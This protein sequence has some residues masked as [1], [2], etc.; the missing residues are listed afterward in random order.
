MASTS[1]SVYRAPGR[2]HLDRRVERVRRLAPE[3][4]STEEAA[5][6][7][8][9]ELIAE[10]QALLPMVR[11]A[12][13]PTRWNPAPEAGDRVAA[14]RRHLLA[15]AKFARADC[16]S[17]Q[18]SPYRNEAEYALKGYFQLLSP[19]AVGRHMSRMEECHWLLNQLSSAETR[20][21]VDQQLAQLALSQDEPQELVTAEELRVATCVRMSI[22][23]S[24][25]LHELG[26]PLAPAEQSS[27]CG[28]ARR[29]ADLL[30]QLAPT[31]PKAMA[32]AAQLLSAGIHALNQT[33]GRSRRPSQQ[34]VGELAA[35]QVAV[36][37]RYRRGWEGAQQRG[38]DLHLA[39]VG[40]NW[41]IFAANNPQS[42]DQGLI[43]AAIAAGPEAVLALKRCKKNLPDTWTAPLQEV[44][45]VAHRQLLP[46]VKAQLDYVQRRGGA[47][48]LLAKQKGAS[49]AAQQLQQPA[50]EKYACDACGQY[51]LALRACSV[52]KSARYCSR[53]CQVNAWKAGHKTQCTA[54]K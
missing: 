51:S 31:C 52:W 20:Q 46:S 29:A 39:T 15:F 48:D 23:V 44:A 17:P 22:F 14:R 4:R 2:E 49:Q 38:S 26:E 10:V 27:V 16:I 21:G 25:L 50:H 45:D 7:E 35:L 43:E 12:Y 11:D 1:G 33:I 42:Q 40:F 30:D 19:T 28:W 36:N 3:K 24:V 18:L 53:E 6:L 37:E 54:D 5:F 41:L 34:Q 13:R 9:A 47:Q 8:G 32:A